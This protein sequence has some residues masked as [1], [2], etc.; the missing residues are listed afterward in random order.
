MP[1][2]SA[3]VGGALALEFANTAGD[4]LADTPSERLSSWARFAQWCLEQDL[5]DARGAAALKTS[6]DALAPVVAARE[7]V[8]RVGLAITQGTKPP[9]GALALLNDLAAGDG[10]R[11]SHT[12]A[13]L[14]WRGTADDGAA[15]LRSLLAREGLSLFCSPRAARMRLCAGPLCGWLFLDDSRGAPRRWC[16]MGDCGNRAKV[17]RHHARRSAAAGPAEPGA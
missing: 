3:G 17:Q 1:G 8:F 12:Q 11:V 16:S 10:P 14:R 4:H 6:V 5:V 13:G 9:A 7:G 2:I 15:S